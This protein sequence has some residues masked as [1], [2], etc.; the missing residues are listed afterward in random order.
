M[1]DFT[2]EY[3]VGD[4]SVMADWKQLFVCKQWNLRESGERSHW[5]SVFIFRT[6]NFSYVMLSQCGCT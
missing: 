4:I 2:A 6:C 5:K 3:E 1:K